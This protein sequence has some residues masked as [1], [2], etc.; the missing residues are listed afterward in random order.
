MCLVVDDPIKG[1]FQSVGVHVDITLS[2]VEGLNY[3]RCQPKHK[4]NKIGS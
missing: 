2:L 4:R 1:L 3:K